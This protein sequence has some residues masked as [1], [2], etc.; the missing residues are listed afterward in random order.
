ME[1]TSSKISSSLISSCVNQDRN[2]QRKLYDVMSPIIYAK[3][4]REGFSEPEAEKLLQTIF[5]K[6]FTSIRN[7]TSTVSVEQWCLEICKTEVKSYNQGNSSIVKIWYKRKLLFVSNS[8][9]S[10]R[11]RTVYK[12]S[13]LN[14][15]LIFNV[16][17]FG[18]LLGIRPEQKF[19]AC[20]R[21]LP[22][23]FARHFLKDYS[24]LSV[25][26]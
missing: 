7:Y 4:V 14:R 3:I 18:T 2:S 1:F 17:H 13:K 8:K 9:P 24:Y 16:L 6:I 20:T 21:Q 15:W 12:N 26:L 19:K 22:K 23:I 10:V 11:I 25:C 5:I